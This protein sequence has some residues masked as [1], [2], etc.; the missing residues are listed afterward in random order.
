MSKKKRRQ[1]GPRSSGKYPKRQVTYTRDQATR[2]AFY[3]ETDRE[4][5][6]G[7]YQIAAG[8]IQHP[9][10]GLWQVWLSTNGLDFT[11]LAAFR[12]PGKAANAVDIIKQ[13]GQAGNLYN[14]GIV[15]ALYEFLAK[16]SDGKALPLPEELIR[17]LARDIQHGVIQTPPNDAAEGES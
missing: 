11:P 8:T 16:Q 4:A 1:Q 14:Q 13:E 15:E 7:R 3:Q 9:D 6:L 2:E 10:T 5:P 12:D 17:K